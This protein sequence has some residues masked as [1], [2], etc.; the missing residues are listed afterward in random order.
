[1]QLTDLGWSPYFESFFEEYRKCGYSPLRIT[2]VN[3][4]NFIATDGSVDF[5][6]EVT[7]RFS[8]QSDGRESYPAV[9]DWVA[10]SV[11]PNEPKAMIH[12]VLPRKSAFVRKV[13]GELSDEQIVASNIDTVFI[14]T[15]L[16]QNFNL[17]RIERYLSLAWES[18]AVP[19]LLLNKSDLCDDSEEKRDAVASIAIGV[20]TFMLSAR[21]QNGISFLHNYITLGK[22]VAFIGSSGVGKSTIINSLL[23]TDHLKVSEVSDLGSRGRHTTTFRELI[24]LPSGGMVI[25]TPGMREIQ[26]W[27][28]ECGLEQTFSDIEELSENC[29]FKD[30]AHVNEP[31]CAIQE[32]IAI[33][34]LD[35][36]RLDNYFK[37]KKEFA[38]LSDRQTMKPSAIEKSRWKNISKYGKELKKRGEI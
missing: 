16:D 12:A 4:G 6:C 38:Y 15:G 32:A 8:F 23:G 29:R 5:S 31:G 22:T 3:R 20:D 18:K 37:L 11:L 10:V 26:V 34:T 7:G 2:R 17:R 25:D 33:G 9:G 14:V 19:V 24:I 13:A 1:M 35:S 36:K 30:C 28:D 21:L 27:G